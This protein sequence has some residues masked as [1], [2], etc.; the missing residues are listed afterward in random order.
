MEAASA[1]W[2]VAAVCITPPK[3]NGEW[4]KEGEK[5]KGE[6][7]VMESERGRERGERERVMERKGE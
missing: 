4:E 6:E 2:D 7:R 5:M 3:L 1:S